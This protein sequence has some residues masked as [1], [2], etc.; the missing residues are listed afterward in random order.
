MCLSLLCTGDT[1]T[2][3]PGFSISPAAANQLTNSRNIQQSESAG[4]RDGRAY[5]VVRIPAARTSRAL[6]GRTEQVRDELHR[7][8]DPI[9]DDVVLEVAVD[10][11]VVVKRR[12]DR[13]VHCFGLKSPATEQLRGNMVADVL[14]QLGTARRVELADQ[15]VEQ[16]VR[17]P[18]RVG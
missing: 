16:P 2:P 17:E 11:H 13:T 1:K 5:A 14:P 6:V 10:R 7:H 15:V 9:S 3:P 12:R 4:I 8:A 18:A